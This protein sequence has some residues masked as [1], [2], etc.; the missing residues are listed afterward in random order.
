E[1]GTSVIID[2]KPGASGIIATAHTARAPADGYTLYIATPG[3]LTILPHLQDVSYD[4]AKFTAISVLVT[5]PNVLVTSTQSGIDSV[6]DLV[7]RAK[8]GDTTYASGGN[9]TI[10]QMA[11]EQ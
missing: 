3:S 5:M 2:N 1:L 6:Q 11:G 10:G 8:P 7:K 4:P 9:G